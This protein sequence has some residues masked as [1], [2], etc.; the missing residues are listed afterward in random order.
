MFQF[1]QF[2]IQQD[3]CAMKVSTDACIL[4]A[5]A[6]VTSAKHILDIGTGTGLL[7][8]MMAQRSTA[9]IDAVEIDNQAF[10]QACSNAQGSRFAA[11]IRLHQERIQDFV[12]PHLYDCIVS[13][14]PFY[15]NYLKSDKRAKNMAHHTDALSFEDLIAAVLRL[16]DKQGIFVVLLPDYEMN[17][18]RNLCETQGLFLQQSLCIRHRAGSKILRKIGVFSQQKQSILS[19]ELHIKDAQEQYTD[20]FKALLQ[21]YYLIF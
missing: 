8:L 18:L 15:Q 12:A 6:P 17:L 1:K 11:Q 21:S 5:Y 16:L 7:A 9:T 3:K 20:A 19:E 10:E 2:T 14:P 13:N 4:G